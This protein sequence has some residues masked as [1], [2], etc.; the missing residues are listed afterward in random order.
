MS[1]RGHKICPLSLLWDG[2]G[3][4]L[5]LRSESC[6][7]S[8]GLDAQHGGYQHQSKVPGDLQGSESLEIDAGVLSLYPLPCG[9]PVWVTGADR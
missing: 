7:R 5:D 3:V 2:L 9:D 4:H 6:V 1:L 8:F